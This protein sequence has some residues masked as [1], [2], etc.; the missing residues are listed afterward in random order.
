MRT[1][2]FERWGNAVMSCNYRPF[3]RYS[4]ELERSRPA[5]PCGRSIC[6][7]CNAACCGRMPLSYII[8]PL[9]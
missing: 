6:S 7:R 1:P 2:V 8:D 3:K 4:G 9:V 5:L